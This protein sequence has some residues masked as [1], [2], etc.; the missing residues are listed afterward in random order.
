M[1]ISR[2][3]PVAFGT[4]PSAE[5]LYT[6]DLNWSPN[7]I[8]TAGN[9]GIVDHGNVTAIGQ[10]IDQ[11]TLLFLPSTTSAKT[12]LTL[13]D[14]RIGPS[15]YLILDGLSGGSGINVN[16]VFSFENDGTID[17]VGA[18][19]SATTF[20][21]TSFIN[22]GTIN[23]FNA[24]PLLTTGGSLEN[25][26]KLVLSNS[27][28]TFISTSIT[29]TGAVI[30]TPNQTIETSASVGSGQIVEFT[31]DSQ[32]HSTIVLDRA[33]V[34]AG[35]I[36]GFS[37]GDRIVLN[38]LGGNVRSVTYQQTSAQSGTLQITTTSLAVSLKFAGTYNQS[39]F[40]TSATGSSVTVGVTRSDQSVANSENV[41]RFFD[42]TNGTHFFTASV[43]ERDSV[44]NSRGDLVYEG[45]GLERQTRPVWAQ[46]P[47]I[48]FSTRIM[49]RIFIPSASAYGAL[50]PPD[51]SFEG[52]GFY[53]HTAQQSGDSAVYRFDTQ[54]GTHFYTASQSEASSNRPGPI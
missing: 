40:A 27:F 39:D 37:A 16:V 47:F 41:Y 2:W 50:H 7:Q 34:F 54:Y 8:P 25:D 18:G 32:L 31:G 11:A 23:F 29:G 45:V 10:P 4:T 21:A 44:L 13:Q 51:L 3:D 36:A 12:S 30:V 26:G 43:S 52:T 14:S 38:G 28:E 1:S 53:G 20:F 19:V 24:A 48:G 5:G 17:L 6:F 22:K 42:T 49:E 46:R 9:T 33:S 35:T 15:T